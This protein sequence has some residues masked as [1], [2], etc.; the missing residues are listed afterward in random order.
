LPR[1]WPARFLVVIA[2]ATVASVP[3]ILALRALTSTP[4]STIYLTAVGLLGLFSGIVGMITALFAATLVERARAEERRREVEAGR[5]AQAVEELQEEEIRVRRLVFD[6]LH[7]T[8]QH[9]LVAVTAGLDRVAEQLDSAGDRSPARDV[10]HWAEALEEI[11]ERDVRSLSHTVFPT[12]ADL[13]TEAAIDMLL[14]R[15]P[16]QIETSIELGPSYRSL[17]REGA[18]MPMAERL[19]AICTVE[20]AVTNALKH[21]RANS[22][23][24]HADAHPTDEPGRW[25]FETVVDDDGTGPSEADPVLHGLRRHHDRITYR[26]GSLSLGTNPDGGGRLAF[27]LPFAV[28]QPE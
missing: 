2:V 17:Q 14:R 18:R 3:R 1:G 8:L 15:L 21:G 24:V 19:V 9:H 11:R 25:V 5:A 28:E 6:Q 10:R 27:T 12:G 22:V 23:R 26:G 4:D 13:G 16:P 20:E 7:G